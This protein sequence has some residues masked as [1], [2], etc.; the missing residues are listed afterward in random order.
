[1]KKNTVPRA[2]T[3]SEILD[4]TTE[5][6][7]S[8]CRKFVLFAAGRPTI[9]IDVS[10]GPLLIIIFHGAV[11]DAPE[12]CARDASSCSLCRSRYPFGFPAGNDR[13]PG[14]IYVAHPCRPRYI[15]F[16]SG[17]PPHLFARACAHDEEHRTRNPYDRDDRLK[18]DETPHHIL[19]RLREN[20]RFDL[21]SIVTAR[22]S[23][24]SACI[25]SRL[26]L[27]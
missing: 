21:F 23:V 3:P 2:T 8:V 15:C 9:I 16:P 1:M 14:E 11:L 25:V 18:Y 26:I 6:T 4:N 17:K 19:R 27:I 20:D 10:R 22:D 12:L 5:A 7:R 24:P 13:G